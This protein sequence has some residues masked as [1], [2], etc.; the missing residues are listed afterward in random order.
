[1]PE[2]KNRLGGPELAAPALEQLANAQREEEKR[3]HEKRPRHRRHGKRG[4]FIVLAALVVLALVGSGFVY[5]RKHRGVQAEGSRLKKEQDAGR[6]VLV[7]KVE[8]AKPERTLTLPGDVRPFTAVG[9]FPK[10]NGYV[11]Q[12]RVDKGDRVKAGQLLALVDSPETDQQVAAARAA[13]RLKRL[14]AVRARRLAPSGVISRQ[15]LDNAIE[16]E[17]SAEADYRRTRALQK[18][19]SV[20]A[21]FDGILTARLVDPGA[22]VSATTPLFELA[23]PSRL[24]VWV[25]VSQDVAPFVRVGDAAELSQDE[26]PGAVVRAQ[27]SRLA[28]ALDSRTRTMLAEIWLDN[29]AGGVVAGVFVHVTLHVRIPPL[30]VVPSNAILSRG[31]KTL[32]A[33]VQDQNK[34]HLVPVTTGLDDGK[35]VQVRQG[36]RGGETVALDVPS[37]LPE[38]AVI[39]PLTPKQQKAGAPQARSGDT[40]KRGLSEEKD[41]KD[42][43]AGPSSNR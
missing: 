16:G 12:V 19:E 42:G 1:M 28:D 13:L 8:V 3:R 34:L 43:E 31:D 36:L 23:D 39:Q 17:R 21:P 15:D 35:T 18:Y 14:T 30:P 5:W 22:L 25:Y 11:R 37:E 6:K 40:P 41:G 38:G 26:R 24:R 7:A 20:R 27:V 9:V 32:V 2:T 4:L 29:A 10:V 33:V